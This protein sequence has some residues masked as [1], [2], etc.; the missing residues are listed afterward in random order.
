[1]LIWCLLYLEQLILN[2]EIMLEPGT[3]KLS[4]ITRCSYQGGGGGGVRKAR[5]DSITLIYYYSPYLQLVTVF[6]LY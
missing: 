3:R 2:F 1:M 5:F 4:A 6:F